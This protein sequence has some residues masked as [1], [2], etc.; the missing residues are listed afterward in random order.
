M[1]TGLVLIYVRPSV[2]A[3]KSLTPT[4]VRIR[5]LLQTE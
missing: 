2:V 1:Y 4:H 3:L 5:F